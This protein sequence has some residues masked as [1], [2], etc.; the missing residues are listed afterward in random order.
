VIAPL[1]YQDTSKQ[2]FKDGNYAFLDLNYPYQGI[3]LWDRGL[4]AP[5]F[6]KDVTPLV[7]TPGGLRT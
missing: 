5:G 7:S 6:R 3:A 4:V 2:V 1:I